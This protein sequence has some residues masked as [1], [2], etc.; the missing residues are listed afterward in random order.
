M[1]RFV[2]VVAVVVALVCC[3]PAAAAAQSYVPI[4]GAGS[5]WAF[6]E[7]DQARTDVVQY[8]MTVN[9]APVG[10][11]AGRTDFRQGV[12]DWAVSDVPYGLRDG[13]AFDP[14]PTR[15]YTYVPAAAGGLGF[16]YNLKIGPR[17]VTDL[18][19][20]GPVVAGIFTGV[21]RTWNDPAIAADNPGLGLP[22]IPIVPVVRSDGSGSTLQ[23]TQWLAATQPT[24]WANYCAAAGRSPC[25]VTS[26]YPTV[27]GSGI[28]AQAGDLGVS[29]Y[30]SQQQADGAIGY[31]PYSYAL[32]T[33]FP[34]AKVLNAAGYYTA[35]TPGHVA[36]SLHAATTNTNPN[37]PLYRSED[38]SQVYTDPDPRTYPL[39]AYSYLVVPTDTTFSFNPAKG[40]TLAEFAKFL[41]CTEQSRVDAL[42]Y[43]ALP[44][45]LV[46][47]GVTQLQRIPGANIPDLTVQTCNNPTFT[48]GGTDTILASDPY[49]PACDAQGAQCVSMPAPTPDQQTI[50]VTVPT[51]S[52]GSLTLSVNSTPVVMAVPTNAGTTLESTGSLSPVTVTD[53][54]LPGQPGWDVTGVVSAFSSGANSFGGS[55]LGWTPAIV[56]QDPAGDVFA[57]GAEQPDN[58]GLGG[59]AELA[60]ATVGH[61]AGTTVLG[62]ALDL[63]IPFTTMPGNYSADL[64]VTLLSR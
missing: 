58:P 16:V 55:A 33:G 51:V 38:L 22:A 13:A 47:N 4:S 63:R 56:T 64:A 14:P 30:V 21:I 36:V 28:V 25:T 5:T 24:A 15:G 18:R 54:R 62:A 32:E 46:Q 3:L 49:P 20:S 1:V 42:G 8:G 61:G 59:P 52:T 10:D 6:T 44:I 57:G 39:S 7:I 34:V 37:D 41:I 35:P 48:T 53:S 11:T 19:L 17:R 29:G 45:N 40:Y 43:A 31:T 9:Y 23:F 2:G 27:A 12:D 50:T 60:G 26:V